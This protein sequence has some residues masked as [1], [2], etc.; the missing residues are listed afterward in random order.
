MKLIKD[1]L[2]EN[3]QELIKKLQEENRLLKRKTKY[4]DIDKYKIFLCVIIII[5]SILLIKGGI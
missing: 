5:E 4:K 3:Q 2:I 1:K